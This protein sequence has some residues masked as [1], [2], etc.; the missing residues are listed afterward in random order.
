MP[1][2]LSCIHFVIEQREK[3]QCL[4]DL[5]STLGSIVNGQSIGD[6]SGVDNV[7]LRAGRTK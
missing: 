4:R 1:F 2:R 3:K 5:A 6:Y 7:Q